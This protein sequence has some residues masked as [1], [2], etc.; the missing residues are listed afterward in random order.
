MLGFTSSE[1]AYILYGELGLI[2]LAAVPVGAWLGVAFAHGLAAAFSRD[3]LRLPV[4]IT[5]RT[6]ALSI[7]AYA[8]S[9]VA[10]C[11]MLARRLWRL[12][13]VAVLKTRE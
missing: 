11:A 1:C 2:A 9:V 5:A 3:E 13:L 8:V 10:G 12:D 4:T 7:T 6:L